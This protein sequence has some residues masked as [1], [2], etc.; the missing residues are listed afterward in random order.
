[1]CQ[2]GRI[3]KREGMHHALIRPYEGSFH[4][5]TIRDTGPFLLAAEATDQ[6]FAGDTTV[7]RAATLPSPRRQESLSP[8]ISP[9]VKRIRTSCSKRGQKGDD[10]HPIGLATARSEKTET[11]ILRELILRSRARARK[12]T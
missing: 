9:S 2:I 12:P 3:S 10:L 1:M 5:S 11:E 6:I 4:H 8:S 7:T